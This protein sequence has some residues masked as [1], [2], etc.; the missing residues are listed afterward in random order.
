MPR[1]Q[2]LGSEMVESIETCLCHRV[3]D[4]AL[5][6][7]IAMDANRKFTFAINDLGMYRATAL[8]DSPFTRTAIH[9]DEKLK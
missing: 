8:S 4:A 2:H 1:G 6:A 7:I 5:A 3:G 9:G